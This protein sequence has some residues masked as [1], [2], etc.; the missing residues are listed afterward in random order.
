ME[1]LISISAMYTPQWYI[2]VISGQVGQSIYLSYLLRSTYTQEKN[3]S[4]TLNGVNGSLTVAVRMTSHSLLT[5]H[6][7]TGTSLI[8]HGS[9]RRTNDY[10]CTTFSTIAGSLSTLLYITQ[11]L[12]YRTCSVIAVAVNGPSTTINLQETMSSKLEL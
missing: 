12:T 9:V 1:S 4:S 5:F 3:I 2:M 10:L 6:S 7:I 11:Q 8:A